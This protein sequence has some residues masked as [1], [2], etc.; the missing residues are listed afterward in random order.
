MNLPLH[1]VLQKHWE[2]VTAGW[3]R[4][5]NR[6]RVFAREEPH[7]HCAAACSAAELQ[8]ASYLT[9]LIWASETDSKS[10]GGW[11]LGSRLESGKESKKERKQRFQLVWT[12]GTNIMSKPNY[13]GTYHTV[14]QEN[15]DAYLEALGEIVASLYLHTIVLSVEA[16]LNPSSTAHTFRRLC[17]VFLY[18]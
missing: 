8:R 17:S 4:F 15:M 18:F 7:I 6:V 5:H 13:S 9:R 11:S 3:K 1:T 16:Q 12:F 2:W 14:E 10:G